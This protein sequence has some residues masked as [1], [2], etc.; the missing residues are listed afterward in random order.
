MSRSGSRVLLALAC[1]VLQSCSS[2]S[3]Y[4]LGPGEGV[5]DEDLDASWAD[6]G[7]ASDGGI[8]ELTQG[9][10]RELE[11]GAC[12]G[13]K[14]E[15]V[16]V[17]PVVEFVVD[18]SSSMEEPAP[19]GSGETKWEATRV[20]L[21][22]AIGMMQD[23]AY[24]GMLLYPNFEDRDQLVEGT[25]PRDVSACVNVDAMIPIASLGSEDSDH[26][27]ALDGMIQAAAH[28]VGTPT[29]DAY[30][31]AL[32]RSL[33]PFDASPDKYMVLITDGMP[34]YN[35]QCMN[36][37]NSDTPVGSQP[38]V[39]DIDRA[40][41]E[42]GIRTFVVGSPGSASEKAWL[43]RAAVLGGTDRDGCSIVGPSNWC[44]L[45]MAEAPDFGKALADG[46]KSVAHQIASCSFELP[47]AEEGRIVDPYSGALVLTDA[48]GA[49]LM[50]LRDNVGE[51]SEGWNF[52]SNGRVV[53]CEA[54]CERLVK[55]PALRVAAY[56]DCAATDVPSIR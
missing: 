13:Q 37:P 20:A 41:A 38:I 46:L 55:D 26:R 29:Y 2:D 44:H 21:A 25:V 11:S 34:T 48:D 9:E 4:E 1:V 27:A 24:V 12:A 3:R 17:P 53:L 52:D 23:D 22:E 19:G 31:H 30:H 18:V 10:A 32:T 15:G 56:F 40:Y 49:S 42:L 8:I 28:N 51:C 16:L 7:E 33:L 47:G 50:V 6:G 39:D 5:P 45:D 54:T 43:S 14:L 36:G 35:P